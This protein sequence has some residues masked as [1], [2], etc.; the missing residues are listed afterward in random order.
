MFVAISR[1]GSGASISVKLKFK[2]MILKKKK[3]HDKLEKIFM[4]ITQVSDGG[5]DD[6]DVGIVHSPRYRLTDKCMWQII[7]T[8][9]APHDDDVESTQTILVRL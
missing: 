4:R 9:F 1:C 8:Q 6:G 2:L 5:S 7:R 3:H